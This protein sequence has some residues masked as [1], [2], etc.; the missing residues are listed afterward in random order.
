MT[1]PAAKYTAYSIEAGRFGLDGGAMFGVVPRPLWSKKSQPDEAGRIPL[2]TRCLLLEGEGR[3]I[4]IDVGIGDKFDTKRRGIYAMQEGPS[5]VDGIRAAGFDPKDVTDVVLTHLHFDHCGGATAYSDGRS[6]VIFDRAVHHVQRAH[7]EWAM[8]SNPREKASFLAENLEPLKA[9]GN[10]NLI[11]GAGPILPGIR[12]QPVNGH[13]E[14]QQII[15]IDGAGDQ[16]L[17]YVADLIPTTAHLSPV[18]GM[19]YDL[20]PLVTIQ[21]KTDFLKQAAQGNWRLFF[22]HDPFVESATVVMG[23][24][25][26]E[27]ADHVAA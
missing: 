27:L 5:L 11:D 15:H 17:V 10:L 19:S 14:A 9:E 12:V 23:E 16:H 22:E 20:L 1:T 7:W 13:T 2:S 8:A 18:W 6:R 21:E 24:R 25:R 3:L 26:A 4:L